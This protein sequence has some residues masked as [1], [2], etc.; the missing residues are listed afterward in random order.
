[1]NAEM[2]NNKIDSTER[3]NKLR[4]IAQYQS[5]ILNEKD[6]MKALK[7]QSETTYI[8]QKRIDE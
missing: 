7:R 6:F 5:K 4:Q 8:K 1:M 3:F 2:I